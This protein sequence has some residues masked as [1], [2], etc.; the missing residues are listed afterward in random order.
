MKRMPFESLTDYYDERL[1]SLD[2]KILW[3]DQITERNYII[4]LFFR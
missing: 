1:E 2:E 4:I 3:L